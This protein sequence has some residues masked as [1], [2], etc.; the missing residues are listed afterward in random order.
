[1]VGTAL[2]FVLFATEERN[3]V[4]PVLFLALTREAPPLN[5]LIR[6]AVSLL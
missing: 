2:L 1:M 5:S 4:V 3:D 6:S